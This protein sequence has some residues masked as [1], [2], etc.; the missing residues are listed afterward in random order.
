MRVLIINSSCGVGSVG[1]ICVDFAK[2]YEKK[3]YEV[4]VTYGRDLEVPKG[5]EKYAVRIGGKVNLICHFIYSRLLDRHGF[6]SWHA[7]QKFLKWAEEYNP[8]IIF[9]HNIHGYY[10]NVEMLFCWIKSHPEKQVRWMLHD[11]WA[12]T[13]HCTYFSFEKCTK[14]QIQCENCE[15]LAK[16]PAS[17]GIDNSI[18]NF[19]KKKELFTGMQNMELI[20]PSY[21]LANLVKKSFLKDYPITVIHN[22]VNTNVFKPTNSDLREKYELQDKKILLGVAFKWTK[23][24]GL[25][26]FKELA[27][28]LPKDYRIVLIGLEKKQLKNIP[29]NIVA[30]ERTQN[31]HELAAWYTTADV[32]VNLSVQETFG[33]TTLEAISCG[34][35]A[36]VYQDTAGEEIIKG[37]NSI[38][39]PRNMEILVKTILKM[40]KE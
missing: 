16:Y 7:T 40:T 32:Y 2:E 19:H 36:I 11:C 4:K 17:C 29:Q 37:T 22:Q 27:K 23:F 12:F 5:L 18:N 33:M 34:T 9:M 21:W 10:L 15:L 13:G 8:D 24:K 25:N 30:I 28:F 38:A 39:V 31:V 6:A 1:R 26:D 14:W 35:K 20:T 3:G